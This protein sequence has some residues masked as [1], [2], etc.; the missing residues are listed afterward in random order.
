MT[1]PEALPTVGERFGF[2]AAAPDSG[3]YLAR[4]RDGGPYPAVLIGFE[5]FGVTP[6]I[7]RMADRVASLGYV[8]AAPD[9]YHREAPGVELA[10]D[11]EGRQRG[12]ELMHGLGRDAVRRDLDAVAGYLDRRPDTTGTAAMVGFSLGGHIGYLAAAHLGLKATAAFY[13]GWLTTTAVPLSTPR[14]TIELTDDITGRVLL[15]VGGGDHLIDAAER[16]RVTERF[17]GTAHEL[18]VYPE[19]PHGFACDE[20]ETYREEPTRDAWDRVAKLLTDA[21]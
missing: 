1:G 4:P 3:G 14:P 21:A 5:I 2:G 13:P 7:R 17:A 6:Y 10:A 8:V 11:A 16:E 15:L 19:A 18:V 12:L 9:F 20:R